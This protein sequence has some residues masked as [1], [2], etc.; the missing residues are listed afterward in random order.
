[1]LYINS[2]RAAASQKNDAG[3]PSRTGALPAPAT[4]PP[5]TACQDRSGFPYHHGTVTPAAP[6]RARRWGYTELS[7]APCLPAVL[8]GLVFLAT[9][10]I[11]FINTLPGKTGITEVINNTHFKMNK[12]MRTFYTPLLSFYPT[13]TH[14][15]SPHLTCQHHGQSLREFIEP[16]HN[17]TA[18]KEIICLYGSATSCTLAVL[19]GHDMTQC[20]DSS[21]F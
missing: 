10:I 17:S 5:A 6:G 1:M 11:K 2:G 20:M 19:P 21:S 3:P 9:T 4:G 8:L 14:I 16:H 18:P 15:I 7:T 13:G 12:I